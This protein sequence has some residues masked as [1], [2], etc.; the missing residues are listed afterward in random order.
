M[1]NPR[2]SRLVRTVLGSRRAARRHP[3]RYL[4]SAALLAAV[5]M[6]GLPAAGATALNSVTGKQI[7]DETLTGLDVR[8]GSLASVE[9]GHLVPGPQGPQGV[10]GAPGPQGPPGAPGTSGWV[11]VVGDGVDI[12]CQASGCR[13]TDMKSANVSCP[14]GK[15]AIGGGAGTSD[16][17]VA[18]L[19]ES[20]PLDT[21][22][23]GWFVT[24][25]NFSRSVPP[26]PLSIFAWAT[27]VT[28]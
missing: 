2:P 5:V 28:P 22:G 10:Q 1:T 21:I 11:T 13:P 12:V 20:G 19:R 15:V 4:A 16:P 24:V 7:R 9:F 18:L 3:V 23:T 27:C 14:D 26:E 6:L 8:D 25:Q 17:A